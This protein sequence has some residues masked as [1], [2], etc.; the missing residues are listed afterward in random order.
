[1]HAYLEELGVKLPHPG[2]VTSQLMKEDF[3]SEEDIKVMAKQSPGHLKEILRE[4]GLSEFMI[5]RVIRGEPTQ[6]APKGRRA[7]TLTGRRP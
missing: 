3:S 1:M 6:S 5:F 2:F 4:I 7:L